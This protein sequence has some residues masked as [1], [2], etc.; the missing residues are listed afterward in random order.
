VVLIYKEKKPMRK[1]NGQMSFFYDYEKNTLD[2]LDEN[3]VYIL[4]R[5]Y[6]F[7]EYHHYT[8]SGTPDNLNSSPLWET[9]SLYTWTDNKVLLSKI[10]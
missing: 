4:G 10:M 3:G 5:I 7:L 9:T 6:Q 1:L 8:G 2:D